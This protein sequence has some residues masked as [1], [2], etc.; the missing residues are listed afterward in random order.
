MHPSVSKLG[1]APVLAATIALTLAVAGLSRATAQQSPTPP[2]T[3]SAS[4][5]ASVSPRPSPT[6]IVNGRPCE[7][8]TLINGFLI[9][10]DPSAPPARLPVPIPSCVQRATITAPPKLYGLNL[11]ADA[12]TMHLEIARGQPL[13]I[14]TYRR[15]A[16]DQQ[17]VSIF[18]TPGY[19][20]PQPIGAR[21]P[22]D[23]SAAPFLP[24]PGV[25][26]D[27]QTIHAAQWIEPSGAFM[28]NIDDPSL[29][30][31]Q[32]ASLLAPLQLQPPNTGTGSA[33]PND[34][35]HIPFVTASLVLLAAAATT[36]IALRRSSC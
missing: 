34:G 29:T 5:I 14:V 24:V 25:R 21:D 32:L 33:P 36:A 2:G 11:P 1:L 3:A 20:I 10:Q 30:I 28:I 9:Y 12:F 6:V 26:Y 17:A 18:F 15:I 19:S 7:V 31:E 13:P 4:P 22:N 23:W 8:G 27:F 35:S 16:T